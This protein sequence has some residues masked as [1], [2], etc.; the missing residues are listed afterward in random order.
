MAAAT[1]V[2][3]GVGLAIS[4]G[5]TAMSF[6]QAANQQKNIRTAQAKADQAMQEARK[7]LEVNYYEQLGIQKEPYELQREALLVQGAQALEGAREADRGAAATA[8]RLQAMQNEAQAGVRTAMGKELMDLAALTATEESRL[9]DINVQLDMGEVAG[10]QQAQADA[11]QAR[12]AAMAQG[13]EGLANTAQQ[14]ANMVPLYQQSAAAKS[15]NRAES[16]YS[17]MIKSGN[18]PSQYMKDGKPMSFQQAFGM[19]TGNANYGTMNPFEFRDKLT[20]Q[21]RDFIRQNNPLN[22]KMPT[23]TQSNTAARNYNTSSNNMN[24]FDFITPQFGYGP[25]N[26]WWMNENP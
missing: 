17:K 13:F 3:A 26:M 25:N 23:T 19:V 6:A 20:Q 21:G 18:I 15:L 2:I 8:G 9:R 24:Y 7:K 10:A 5:S 16:D 12:A 11:E 22:Y 14:A 4:A 1:T